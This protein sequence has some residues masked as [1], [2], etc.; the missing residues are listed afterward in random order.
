MSESS[1]KIEEMQL[2]ELFR[3]I[4]EKRKENSPQKKP[5]DKSGHSR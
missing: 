4:S 3:L 5:T 2:Q 1:R